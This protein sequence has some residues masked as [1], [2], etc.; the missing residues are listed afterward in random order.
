MLKNDKILKCEYE[1][2]KC[3]SEYYENENIIRY[4]DDQIKDMYGHNYTYIK[5]ADDIVELQDIIQEEIDLRKS[6]NHSYCNIYINS[7]LDCTQ[8]NIPGFSTEVSKTGYYIFDTSNLSRFRSIE[9]CTVRQAQ[10]QEDLGDILY[11]DLQNDGERIGIDFCERRCSRRGTVYLADGGVNSYVC[12]HNGESIGTCDLFIYNGTA[13]IEDFSVVEKHQR[14]GYGTVILK[15]LI[16]IA[17]EEN[18]HTI[19][20]ATDEDDTAKEMYQKLGFSK[21]GE[22][23]NLFFKL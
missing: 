14:K 21:I 22:L 9:G 18:C 8:I 11:C 7:N 20:L 12:R 23:S 19:Y 10:T 3:F 15:D 13:K 2:I 16:N 4:H 5:K 17:L 6:K 1:Y